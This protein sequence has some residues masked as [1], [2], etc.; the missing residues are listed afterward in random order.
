MLRGL[1]ACW[2]RVR[3]HI[4]CKDEPNTLLLSMGG[5]TRGAKAAAVHWGSEAHSLVLTWSQGTEAKVV[6]TVLAFPSPI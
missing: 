2:I 3:W 5:F 1:G 6:V 4:S